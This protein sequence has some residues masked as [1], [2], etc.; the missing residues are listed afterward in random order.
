MFYR[1]TAWIRRTGCWWYPTWRAPS[2]PPRTSS[3]QNDDRWWWFTDV[4][5]RLHRWIGGGTPLRRCCQHFLQPPASK[6]MTRWCCCFTNIQRGSHRLTEVIHRGQHQHLLLPPTTKMMTRW[7][8]WCFT[9]IQH[10]SHRQA[11]GDT[12]L[13]GNCQHLLQPP[14]TKMIRWWWWCF[15]DIHTVWDTRTSWQGYLTQRAPSAP[16]PTFNNQSDDKIVMTMLIQRR[17]HGY[18]DTIMT[19]ALHREYSAIC[20]VSIFQQPRWWWWWCFTDVQC[21]PHGQ[22]DRGDPHRGRHLHL[23]Q[24]CNS[25]GSGTQPEPR[26]HHNTAETQHW[27]GWGRLCSCW[28]HYI[29]VGWLV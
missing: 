4:Q 2:T 8:W 21:G 1:H 7:W 11:G 3:N 23:L 27:G 22:A 19:E 15:T 17:S 6:M 29:Q 24:W 20:T 16:P 5:H 13:R 12:P 10:G 25:E 9:D 26:T 14:T 18:V 28:V